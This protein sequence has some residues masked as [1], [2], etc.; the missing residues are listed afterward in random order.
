MRIPVLG[1][2]V[3]LVVSLLMGVFG[4][5]FVLYQFLFGDRVRIEEEL[6]VIGAL[7]Y[8][9]AIVLSLVGLYGLRRAA[10]LDHSVW[11]WTGVV[12][13]GAV[14]VA[15]WIVLPFVIWTAVVLCSRDAGEAFRSARR[16]LE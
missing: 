14:G 1:C 5:V 4:T 10:K 6:G 12:I 2:R 7:A 13:S 16:P 9:L 8:P 15:F 11:A 3:I